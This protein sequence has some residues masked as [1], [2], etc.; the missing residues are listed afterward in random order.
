MDPTP[1]TLQAS[2]RFRCLQAEL[3]VVLTPILTPMPV[4]NGELT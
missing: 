4:N 2:S 1:H 3:A